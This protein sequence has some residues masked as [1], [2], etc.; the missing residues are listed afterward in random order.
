MVQLIGRDA[1]LADLDRAWQRTCSGVPELGVVWGRRRVGKTFLL[2]HFAEGKRAVYFTATRQ[3]SAERQ[4]A[5]LTDRVREQLGDKVDDLLPAPFRD[6][7]TA[8]RFLIRLAETEPLLVVIDEAP[9]LLSSQP[10][11]ADLVS[12]VWENRVR[13]QRLM[14]V[15]TGS[16]VSVMEQMLGAQGGLHR[17]PGVELRLDPFPPHEARAF[18]PDIPAADFLLAYAVCGGYPLHL[19]QWDTSQAPNENLLRLSYAPAGIL[20]RDALDIIGEDLDWRGGYERVLTAI[21]YGTRRR[22]RIAG[23]AQQRIDYTLERLRRAGYIRRV[24]PAGTT[25]GDPLYE[26]ADDYLA[27]WFGVLRDDVDLIEGG[28]GDAVRHRTE[29]LLQRHIGR[30]FESACRDHA[31]RLVREGVFPRDTVIGRWWRDEA[32]EIDILGVSGN[33]PVLLGECRWQAR[34]LDTRDLL[35]LQR[36]IAYLPES[37][38]DVI[39]AFWIR[40]GTAGPAFPANVYSAA[41]VLGE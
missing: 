9:R 4:L 30:V 1:E 36:K 5:R 14:L 12:A 38:D 8:L 7:E 22:S 33:Q 24:T 34:P 11:F 10:D 16:A 6:W 3:D 32:A 40:S 19:E 23:R 25:A 35:E 2:T 15:L 31:V 29:P 18:L 41:D 21:G 13:G 39:L 37:A 27:F 26:I 20:V 17:R 28:Q